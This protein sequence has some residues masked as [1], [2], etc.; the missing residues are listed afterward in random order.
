MDCFVQQ[1]RAF[2]VCMLQ[3]LLSNQSTFWSFITCNLSRNT[4]YFPFAIFSERVL[5]KTKRS[6]ALQVEKP[7]DVPSRMWKISVL[8]HETSEL[9]VQRCWGSHASIIYLMS[10]LVAGEAPGQCSPS[11]RA[12][13]EGWRSG[14]VLD[15]GS[16]QGW[17]HTSHLKSGRVIAW[18]AGTPRGHPAVT[19]AKGTIRWM[20]WHVSRYLVGEV[21]SN[22]NI[23]ATSL[24]YLKKKS[25]MHT[26]N[27]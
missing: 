12:K 11:G 24:F 4:Q 14:H 1:E 27:V 5:R 20:N 3:H 13:G 19:Y 21:T 18:P 22:N 7:F 2:R 15:N 16:S 10:R 23:S 25:C 8:L 26:C 17:T 9:I 6:L